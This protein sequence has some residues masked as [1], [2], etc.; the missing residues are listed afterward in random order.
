MGRREAGLKL[1]TEALAMVDKTN[2]RLHEAEL[3]RLYGEL[4]LQQFQVQ[5]SKFKVEKGEA[6]KYF[7]RAIEVARKQQAK[8]PELRATTSL[9]RL[10]RQQGKYNKARHSLSKIDNRFTEGFDTR[11]LQEAKALLEELEYGA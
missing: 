2:E 6:E 7:L 5:G 3:Y 8:S 4:T 10:W 1:L 9:A 11:D